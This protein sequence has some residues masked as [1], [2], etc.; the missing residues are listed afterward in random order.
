MFELFDHTFENILE[1]MIFLSS[2]TK[3][4][5]ASYYLLILLPSVQSYCASTT[6]QRPVSSI[7]DQL[8]PCLNIWWQWCKILLKHL[9][10]NWNIF[11]K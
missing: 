9:C 3:T 2:L 8:A 6:F 4:Y 7:S 5:Q 1:G 11:R 10:K